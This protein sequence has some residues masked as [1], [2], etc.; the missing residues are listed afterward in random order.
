[1]CECESETQFREGKQN[2]KLVIL[3]NN[4]LVLLAADK[5]YVGMNKDCG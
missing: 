3:L 2:L 5:R 1:M 4:L